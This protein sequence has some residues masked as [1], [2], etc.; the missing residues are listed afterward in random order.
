[1]VLVDVIQTEDVESRLKEQ[2][3][4]LMLNTEEEKV[5]MDSFIRKRIVSTIYRDELFEYF[6]ADQRINKLI[7]YDEY[8][9][10]VILRKSEEKYINERS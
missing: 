4:L 7:V 6:D 10:D 1:M 3:I 5:F 8:C 9:D 2:L